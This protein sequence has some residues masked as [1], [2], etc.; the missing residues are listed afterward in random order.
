MTTQ[1]PSA[2]NIVLGSFFGSNF[3]DLFPRLI[4][5]SD[6]WMLS[7]SEHLF[8]EEMR[9]A[10]QILESFILNKNSYAVRIRKEWLGEDDSRSVHSRTL[11]HAP[12]P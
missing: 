2:S 9:L 1:P 11:W 6:L 8:W 7:E 5:M 3:F 4:P 12:T 10:E